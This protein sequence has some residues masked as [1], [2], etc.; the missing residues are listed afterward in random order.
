[1]R[2]CNISTFRPLE[3][4][5]SPGPAAHVDA[6]PLVVEVKVV[7]VITGRQIHLSCSGSGL[8]QHEARGDAVDYANESLAKGQRK[9]REMSGAPVREHSAGVQI[10]DDDFVRF[11][12]VHE[13]LSAFAIDLEALR[14]GAE[15]YSSQDRAMGRVEDRQSARAIADLR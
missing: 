7:G 12:D 4:V 8:S 13:R 10:N 2:G 6:A 1:M 15:R 14:V 5:D 3:D 11:R 9:L